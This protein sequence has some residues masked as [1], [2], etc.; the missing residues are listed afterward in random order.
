MISSRYD[1]IAGHWL[2]KSGSVPY[3]F[4]PPN[5]HSNWENKNAASMYLEKYWMPESSQANWITL[6]NSIF[7][8]SK[9]IPD[10]I[11]QKNFEFITLLGGIVFTPKNFDH[12]QRCMRAVGDNEFA[13]IQDMH[14]SNVEEKK[15][16]FHMKYPVNTSWTE[17]ISGKFISSI[18]FGTSFLHYYIFGDSGQ[19]GMYSANEYINESVERGG[20]PINIIGFDPKHRTIFREAFEIPDGAYC[21]NIDYIPE[22]KRPDLQ[23]RVPRA[24]RN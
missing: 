8:L 10:Q 3:T 16:P 24:Y 1:I 20:S 17:L 18:L 15:Y 23:A 22:E 19:W 13:V 7:D 21:E 14:W 6:Q 9:Q 5:D 12:L 2:M 4:M 11:F